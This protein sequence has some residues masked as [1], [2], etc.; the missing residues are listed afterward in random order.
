MAGLFGGYS[1]PSTGRPH[2]LVPVPGA[3]IAPNT[4]HAIAAFFSERIFSKK[5]N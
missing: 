4:P 1:L 5:M 3:L 2:A